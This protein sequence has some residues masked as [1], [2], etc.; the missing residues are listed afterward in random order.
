MLYIFLM[1]YIIAGAGAAIALNASFEHLFTY[2]LG[3]VVMAFVI[4]KGG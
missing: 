2:M 1:I 3:G 4:K